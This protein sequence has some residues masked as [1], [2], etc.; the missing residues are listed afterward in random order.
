MLSIPITLKTEPLVVMVAFGS[1]PVSTLT[2]I[3]ASW[4]IMLPS[5]LTGKVTAPGSVTSALMEHLAPKSRFVVV[6]DTLPSS[7]SIKTF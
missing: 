3:S 2:S 7:A 5:S 1:P 4:R 6:K